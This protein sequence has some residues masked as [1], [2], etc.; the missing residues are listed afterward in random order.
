MLSILQLL[1]LIRIMNEARPEDKI[2]TVV[3]IPSKLVIDTST[4]DNG[5][6]NSTVIDTEDSN[7]YTSANRNVSTTIADSLGVENSPNVSKTLNANNPMNIPKKNRESSNNN[8]TNHA[9]TPSINS[10]HVDKSSKSSPKID[11][12]KDGSQ[13]SSTSFS[14]SSHPET[15]VAKDGDLS[16]L[17]ENVK[18]GYFL[19]GG[20]ISTV[21]RAEVESTNDFIK[22]RRW[23]MRISGCDGE[24]T[25]LFTR[26]EINILKLLNPN[27]ISDPQPTYPFLLYAAENIANPFKKR[28]GDD[29]RTKGD[30]KNSTN[31]LTLR[32]DEYEEYKKFLLDCPDKMT[33]L[34]VEYFQSMRSIFK[35]SRYKIPPYKVRCFWR[36]LFEKLGHAHERGVMMRDP[37]KGNIMVKDGQIKLFDWNYGKVYNPNKPEF[38]RDGALDFE[39]PPEYRRGR[40]DT[41]VNSHAFDVWV[42]AG[43]IKH[44]LLEPD[45]KF[46]DN[47]KELLE[48]LR[49][50]M[51]VEDA[52]KRPTLLWFLEHHEYFSV[53]KNNESCIL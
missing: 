28:N 51:R 19:G 38:V 30:N 14:S 27:P 7:M 4:F 15:F 25:S 24:D 44:M 33:I 41:Y 23:I 13:P 37:R 34:I 46:W 12:N 17:M 48:D 18:V 36:Q 52:S 42:L 29:D 39:G 21:F 45:R 40:S 53:E 22:N 9:S 50:S 2:T 3:S 26:N 1:G 32:S 8:P 35:D 20:S 6:K 10:A 49:Q 11:T 31:I 16:W 47:D 5:I 43:W